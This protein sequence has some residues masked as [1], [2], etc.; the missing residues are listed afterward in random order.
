[1]PIKWSPILTLYRGH[2]SR[3]ETAGV[4]DGGRLQGA[5]ASSRTPQWPPI[6]G[7]P[8]T[9]VPDQ[10]TYDVHWHVYLS[11]E[12]TSM[13]QISPRDLSARVL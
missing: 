3:D 5:L 6:L 10:G 13:L 11:T 2:T 4:S 12:H 8:R 1:M 7:R 9:R